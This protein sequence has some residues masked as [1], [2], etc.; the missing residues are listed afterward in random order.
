V[1][2]VEQCEQALHE[3]AGRLARSESSRR[4]LGFDRTI[5]C[6]LRDLGVIFAGRLK[7]GQLIDIA[8]AT[9][10]DAQVRLTM[11]SDD[12]IAM[13]D[14]KLKLAT[15]WATGRARIDA[16]VRDVLSLRKFF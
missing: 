2:T 12:L 5:T 4:K 1:A 6:T 9:N 8:P 3:L 7:D 15:A 10:K 14:G 16:S 13:V 11:N